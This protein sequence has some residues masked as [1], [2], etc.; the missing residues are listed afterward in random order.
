[1]ALVQSAEIAVLE[2]DPDRAAEYALKA[3]VSDDL[4]VGALEIMAVA[5]RLAGRK[6]EV[7]RVLGWLLEVD[8]LDHLAR[9]ERYLGSRKPE[10]LEACR[11]LIRSELAHETWLEMAAFYARLGRDGDAAEALKAA[12]QQ[13]TV[14]Y[15]LAYLLRDSAPDG[16]RRLSR[17]GLGRFAP[18]RLPVPRGGDPRVLV[19]HRRPPGRL[20]TEVLSRPH[21]LGQ[22]PA[23]RSERPLR[24]VRGRR[25]CAL[26]PRPR[27]V[28]REDR[29]GPGR[30]RPRQGRSSST[31][32]A[33]GPAIR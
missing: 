23:R 12:P 15:T 24:D 31:P 21:P 32:R 3:L 13:T 10:D 22:G 17:K 20:E 16:E 33:G 26:L 5:H 6:A 25:L 9:F 8:P 18:S 11:A 2:N 30:R 29:R 14:L 19:G 1:M 7:D 28:L 4:N 27:R